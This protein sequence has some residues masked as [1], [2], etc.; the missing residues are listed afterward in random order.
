MR[1]HISSLSVVFFFV[2]CSYGLADVDDLKDVGNRL[3]SC[4]EKW[5]FSVAN[6]LSPWPPPLKAD[7]VSIEEHP[8]IVIDIPTGFSRI[9]KTDYFL[10]FVYNNKKVLTLEEISKEAFPDLRENTKN[11]RMTMADAALATFTK[12]TKD[13]VPDCT[14]DMKF[15]YW[16]MFFKMAFFENGSTVYASKKGPLTA[17]Y[18]TSKWNGGA[19]VNKAL[20]VNGNSPFY[21]LKLGSANMS[22]DEFKSIIGTIKEK[23]E[24]KP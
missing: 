13:T 9:R 10:M 5:C 22:F 12:T 7:T 24:T 4:E 16:A 14:D 20:I 17:Y 19:I 11:S 21:L 15:W 2:A 1:F 6:P 18:V 8:A 3:R 23:K